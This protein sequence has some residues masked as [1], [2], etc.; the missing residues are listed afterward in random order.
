MVTKASQAA[1]AQARA[2]A[3]AVGQRIAGIDV[4]EVDPV[5]GVSIASGP[6]EYDL[7]RA[8]RPAPP[9]RPVATQAGDPNFSVTVVMVLRVAPPE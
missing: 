6:L 5:P 3:T 7:A 8:S 1:L 2:I 9:V 4:V